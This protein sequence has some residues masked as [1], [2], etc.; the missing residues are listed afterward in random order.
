MSQQV[1]EPLTRRN[2]RLDLALQVEVEDSHSRLGSKVRVSAA[3]ATLTPRQRNCATGTRRFAPCRPAA[4]PRRARHPVRGGLPWDHREA[5]P[6]LSNCRSQAGLGPCPG[7]RNCLGGG[8]VNWAAR[9]LGPTRTF[10]HATSCRGSS[11]NR[12]RHASGV[13]DPAA[14]RLEFRDARQARRSPSLL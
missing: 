13:Q 7:A 1:H 10:L 9:V 3:P 14:D 6:A 4:R 8:I 2:D 5:I 11:T 12:P